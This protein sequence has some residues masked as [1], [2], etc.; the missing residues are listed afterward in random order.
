MFE[1]LEDPLPARGGEIALPQKPGLGV[2]PL[3]R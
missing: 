3:V 1:G 2:E